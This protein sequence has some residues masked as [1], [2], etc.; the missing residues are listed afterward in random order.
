[1]QPTL[2]ADRVVPRVPA[3]LTDAVEQF[4]SEMLALDRELLAE[5]TTSS[6]HS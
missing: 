6:P 3:T 4:K 5:T 2:I 1:M